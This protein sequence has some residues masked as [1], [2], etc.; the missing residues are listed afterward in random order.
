MNRPTYDWLLILSSGQYAVAHGR[1]AWSDTQAYIPHEVKRYYR[2]TR[3]CRAKV[4]KTGWDVYQK[5][6][7][8]GSIRCLE[9]TWE[10]SNRFEVW[11]KTFDLSTAA[12]GWGIDYRAAIA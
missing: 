3:K 8:L 1:K 7:Y 6:I 9:G 5:D 12:R 4:S 10:T 11:S 2:L